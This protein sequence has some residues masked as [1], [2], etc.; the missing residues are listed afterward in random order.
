MKIKKSAKV[1]V[2]ANLGEITVNNLDSA[3]LYSI[4]VSDGIA[5]GFPI[6]L[7]QEPWPQTNGNGGVY[8][9]ET[10]QEVWFFVSKPTHGATYVISAA[11]AVAADIRCYSRVGT[12]EQI[13]LQQWLIGRGAI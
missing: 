4:N 9:P 12:L 1:P 2:M 7:A 11:D 6:R 13:A 5:Y 10:D 8:Y 3:I